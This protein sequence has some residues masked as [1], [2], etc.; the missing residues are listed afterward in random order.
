VF[1]CLFSS[2]IFNKKI[3]DMVHL[4]KLFVII[5][6]SLLVGCN[7]EKNKDTAFSLKTKPVDS[8]VL[9]NILSRLKNCGAYSSDSEFRSTT[10]NNDSI[11]QII[12]PL[13]DNGRELK[14]ELLSLIS[15]SP[16]WQ[17]LEQNTKD[18][19]INLTDEQLAHLSL[20][21]SASHYSRQPGVIGSA[22]HDCVGVAL[23]IAGLQSVFATLAT[24]P[25]VSS[26]IGVLRWIGRRFASYAAAVWM[27]WDFWD[28][29]SH[30]N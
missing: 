17:T 20:A 18:T 21:F 6:I 19:I 11:A 13:I 10:A 5:T 29:M 2:D 12:A 1:F 25:S 15:N 28:C 8:V 16:D 30:F 26:A 24:T 7:K 9:R 3:L 27:I 23:G 22:I 14:G 4:V